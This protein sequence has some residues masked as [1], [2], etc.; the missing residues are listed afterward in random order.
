MNALAARM[1]FITPIAIRSLAANTAVG[2]S[3]SA[4]SSCMLWLPPATVKSLLRISSLW[5]ASCCSASA[6]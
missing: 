3:G 1:A 6:R 2:R 5:I 4:S